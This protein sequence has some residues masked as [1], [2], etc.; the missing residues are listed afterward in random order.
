MPERQLT[1]PIPI[2]MRLLG[3]V[4]L[5]IGGR[6]LG[7]SGSLTL[8]I[9]AALSIERGVALSPQQLGRRLWD[10][11]PPPTYRSSLQNM[12]AR[13]RAAIRDAGLS[14]T[15]L[16][17][18]ESGCYRL[19]IRSDDC[20]LH[21]FAETRAKA[22]MARERHDYEG[23]SEIFGQALAEWS[24]DALDGLP[25]SPFVDGFRIRVQEER[26]QTVIDH[27]DMEI[28]CGRSR[29]VIGE[30]R[31]MTG[32][33][34]ASRIIARSFYLSV[35]DAGRRAADTAGIDVGAHAGHR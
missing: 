18:T 5:L 35:A 23:A 1:A 34:P 13:I 26:R 29:Q 16:L 2:N 15:D 10:G 31:V 12:V 22:V 28:A 33:N 17:R 25:A 9:L 30:L 21:R 4:R 19:D 6:R 7:L 11:E 20:D 14:D 32:A 27:I 24:G 3:P 8:T